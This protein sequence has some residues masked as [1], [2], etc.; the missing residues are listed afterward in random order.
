MEIMRGCPWRCRFCQSTTSKRPLR[1]RSVETLVQAAIE[2]CRNTGYDELSLLSLST[3]DYPHFDELLRR[4]H[5]AL[6]PLGVSVSVPSLRVNEQLRTV[7]QSLETDRHSGL[8]IAPEVALDDMRQ[9][10]G[11][12]IRNEDLFEGCRAAFERGFQRVK[13]YFMCGLP[14]ERTIDLDGII[15]MS[16]QISRLGKEVTGRYAMVVA[17]VSNFVPKPH[18]PYQWN[19]MQRADYFREAHRHLWR[20]RRFRTVDVKCHD[21]EASLLEGVLARGD[22]RMGR[23]IESAWRRGARFDSWSDQHRPEIWREALAE[24]AI[25]V[26]A[27]LHHAYPI[28]TTLPWDHIGIRQGRPHLE[29]EQT[30]SLAQRACLGA[31]GLGIRD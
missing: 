27:M 22:R 19:A 28:E 10:I 8:T 6:Q 31:G 7:S 4:L 1:F 25:D 23:V 11:K 13:L 2:S 3:S 18:T 20:R 26:E 14:G 29:Q 16:D 15:E 9:Q 21:V 24:A 12:Q 30:R 17:N 5:E